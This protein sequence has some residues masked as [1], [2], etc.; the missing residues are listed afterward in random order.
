[1]S[2][3]YVRNV[4]GKGKWGRERTVPIMDGVSDIIEKYMIYRARKLEELGI[5]SNSMF[6]P[7]R[8]N[9]EFV[10]QQAFG[11]F[12]ARVEKEIGAKFELRSGRR[13]FG[14][15]ALDAGHELKDV[16][17]V[18][19][20]CTTKTTESFYASFDQEA[21]CGNMLAKSMNM[22]GASRS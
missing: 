20:H 9:S 13:A 2:T 22:R 18:M 7:L 4:K 19:G 12:K 1:M 8:S 5:V 10:C 3:I 11:H 6:P 16:S 15:R 14:Q 17:K 21:S